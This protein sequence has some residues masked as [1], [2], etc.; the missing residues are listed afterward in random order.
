MEQRVNA[1]SIEWKVC[2][3]GGKTRKCW[4]EATQPQARQ[5]NA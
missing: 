4:F 2:G 5:H 3:C 1:E